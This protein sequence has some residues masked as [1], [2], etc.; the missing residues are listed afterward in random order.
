[1]E[2]LLVDTEGRVVAVLQS[3]TDVARVLGRMKRDSRASE[4]VRVVRHDE[5]GGAVMSASSFVTA[6]PL[7]S[8]PDPSR[9]QR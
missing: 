6:S 2:Y 7:P 4:R 8:L 9:Q 5:H 1:V 3:L